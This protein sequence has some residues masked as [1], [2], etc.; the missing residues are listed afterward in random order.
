MVAYCGVMVYY[1]PSQVPF[2]YIEEVIQV[3]LTHIEEA[4]FKMVETAGV[5]G[6]LR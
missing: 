2:T 3:S 6:D 4:T 1:D 5:Y